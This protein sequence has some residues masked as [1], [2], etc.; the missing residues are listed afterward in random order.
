MQRKMP[1]IWIACLT[2][3]LTISPVMAG[4]PSGGQTF[5]EDI[6]GMKIAVN[7]TWTLIAAFLVFFMQLGF[8]LLGAGAI[9][10]RETANYLA[11]SYMD[12]S[13]GAIVFVL[14]GFAIM[15]GGSGLAPGLERG[16][17]LIGYSGWLLLGD[18]YDVTTNMVFLFQMMFAA[19][20]AT[21]VAGAIAGRTKFQAYLIYTMF[22]TAIIYPIYGH[23]VWGGGWLQN[24]YR[25]LPFVGEGI[26]ARD[27]AGSGVVHAIGGFVALAAAYIVGPRIGKFNRDGSPNTIPGHDISY[28]VSGT[29]ILFFGWFGF[30]PGSTLAATDLRISVIAVNTFL[31]GAAGAVMC[32]YYTYF[33]TGKPDITMICS[34]AIGGLVG[35]TAP[36]AYVA[37]WAAIIIG[38]V[39]GLIVMGGIKFNER[40][41]KIDDPVG[42]IP[43]HAYAGLWGLLSL[44][45][46]A[47]GT[48]GGVGGLIVGNVGQFITQLISMLVVALWA[49]GTGFTLFWTVKHTIGLRIPVEEELQGIDLS[50]HAIEAY[51]EFVSALRSF[52]RRGT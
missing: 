20:A 36:C 27:F 39:A 29:F 24:L 10:T 13:I 30:N 22:V 42:A 32:S 41:L 35:I 52:A 6:T 28:I 26:G 4:D 23:W 19:T 33:K 37:P 2:V 7:F 14:F 44:G 11:K 51:P 40:V 38:F 50:E 31:A 45:I 48:Y 5:T 21:I 9:R 8:A 15:F 43:C 34:G 1:K 18:A 25:Y 17:P 49:F 12:F 16:N 46:F 3:I 47:D